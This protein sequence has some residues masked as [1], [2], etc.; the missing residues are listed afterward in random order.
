M[1]LHIIPDEKFIDMAYRAFEKASPN[2]NKYVIVGEKRD[3]VYLKN[4]PAIFVSRKYFLS[5]N[6]AERL[7]KYDFVVLHY[8][9]ELKMKLVLNA[10]RGIKFVWIGWGGDA[11]QYL[12]IPLLLDKTNKLFDSH[13]TL[14]NSKRMIVALKH[15]AKILLRKYVNIDK[16]FKKISYYAPVLEEEYD[17][18]KSSFPNF[19]PKY[20]GWNYGTIEEDL[21]DELDGGLIGEN[22]L[23]GN[24]STYEN[25]HVEAFAQLDNILVRDRKI[26][27]PLVYGDEKYRKSIIEMGHRSFGQNFKPLVEYIPRR[28]YNVI[29]RSCSVL[30]MNHTRQQAVG[31]IITGMYYGSKIFLRKENVVYKYFMKKGARVY[32][33]EELNENNIYSSL[34]ADE[35][36][37]N[38]NILKDRWSMEVSHQRTLTL[39]NE[40]N[41][42]RLCY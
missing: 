5:K 8:L 17:L 37:I 30:I 24:S 40:L 29:V 11:Y 27:V 39:I 13:N 21:V 19:N 20:L 41:N 28:D 2:N 36:E 42:R 15:I 14:H 18:M 38:R 22:I 1:I 26:I 23:L 31:N 12:H 4:T 10:P 25:N 7:I 35:I 9:S 34:T 16:V 33:M 3:Y 6:Y 32:S